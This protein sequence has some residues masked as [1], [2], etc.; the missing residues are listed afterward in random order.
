M[1]E[2]S[3][4]LI[5]RKQDIEKLAVFGNRFDLLKMLRHVSKGTRRVAD[6]QEI[7][8]ANIEK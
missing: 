1:A 6:V 4:N 8:S 2:S 7:G 5:L 3:K